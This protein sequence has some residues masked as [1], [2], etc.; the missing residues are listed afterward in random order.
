ME[1]KAIRI[2]V[3]NIEDTDVHFEV[4]LTNGINLTSIDFYGYIDEFHIFAEEL[5]SFPK[6]INHKIEYELG[7]QGEKW[8]YYIL[9]RVYCYETNGYSAIQVK[10][11]NNRKE[12]YKNYSEFYILTVPASI[13][14]LGQLLKS[15]NPKNENEIEWIAE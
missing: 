15:W 10:I 6:N 7:E 1:R 14:K 11:D 3:L 9:L 4:E 13:N 5:C 8:A 12:P 2:K